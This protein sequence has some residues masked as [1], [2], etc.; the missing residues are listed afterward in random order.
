MS[1]K[2]ALWRNLQSCSWCPRMAA[3]N[4]IPRWARCRGSLYLLVLELME[5]GR[6]HNDKFIIWSKRDEGLEFENPK[7][8]TNWLK[9]SSKPLANGI[10]HSLFKGIQLQVRGLYS[11]THIYTSLCFSPLLWVFLFTLIKFASTKVS[12]KEKEESMTISSL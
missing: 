7:M 11:R 9:L 1:M 10:C 5:I 6:F 2:K 8:S 12:L 4:T 3:S